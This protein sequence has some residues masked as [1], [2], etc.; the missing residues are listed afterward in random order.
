M[1]FFFREG[2]QAKVYPNTL[3]FLKTGIHTE[4]IINGGFYRGEL[5]ERRESPSG[6]RDLRA[7]PA[8][9]AHTPPSIAGH[10]ACSAFRLL[11]EGAKRWRVLVFTMYA[12]K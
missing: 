2:R 8:G 3:A 9:R 4:Y 6:L 10:P 5:L 11:P 1:D 12:L 7:Q